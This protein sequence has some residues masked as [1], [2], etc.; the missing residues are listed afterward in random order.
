MLSS[1]VNVNVVSNSSKAYPSTSFWRESPALRS[2]N[3]EL[4]P[5]SWD[6]ALYCFSRKLSSPMLVLGKLSTSTLRS[7]MRPFRN[8]EMLTNLVSTI[9]SMFSPKALSCLYSKG[10]KSHEVVS[11]HSSS[12]P[13][14]PASTRLQTSIFRLKAFETMAPI[15]RLCSVVENASK[16]PRLM[17]SKSQ[18]P[19]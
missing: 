19:G 3:M 10:C 18:I 5:S 1:H 12:Y 14:H 17:N 13:G 8:F 6:D 9:F 16:E 2:D 15:L 7:R 4:P 11:E